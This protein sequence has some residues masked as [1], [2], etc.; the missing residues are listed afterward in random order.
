MFSGAYKP[1]NKEQVVKE[2]LNKIG[3]EETQKSFSTTGLHLLRKS[4]RRGYDGADRRAKV[5]TKG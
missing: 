2:A 1:K 5:R 4:Q 3:K